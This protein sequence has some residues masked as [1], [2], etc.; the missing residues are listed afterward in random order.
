MA[1]GNRAHFYSSGNWLQSSWQPKTSTKKSLRRNPSSCLKVFPLWSQILLFSIIYNRVQTHSSYIGYRA[2]F[3]FVVSLLRRV[4]WL[5]MFQSA[6]KS[7]DMGTQVLLFSFSFL[8]MVVPTLTLS[9]SLGPRGLS[10]LL[11]PDKHSNYYSS[12]GFHPGPLC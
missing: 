3:F 6:V 7:F 12:S 8:S 1:K 2:V 5:F 4:G 10:F 9:L 11:L